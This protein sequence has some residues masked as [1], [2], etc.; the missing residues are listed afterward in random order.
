MS[1]TRALTVGPAR[2][3]SS[4]APRT[5]RPAVLRKYSAGIS[6]MLLAQYGLGITACR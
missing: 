4:G 2:Q 6:V 1:D 5:R 3:A